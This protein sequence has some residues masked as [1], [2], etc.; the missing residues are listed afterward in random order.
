[1]IWNLNTVALLVPLLFLLTGLTITVMIDPYISRRNRIIM[2]VILALSVTLIA[3][4]LLE[5][6]LTAGPPQWFW[7]TTVA[8]YGY[9]VRPVFLILFL[10]I[11]QPEKKHLLA[12]GLAIVNWGIYMTAYFSHLCFWI[13]SGN[14][15]FRGP[16]AFTCLYVSVI[17]LGDLLVQSIRNNQT[18]G[19]Q[20]KLIPIF[21]VVMIL[22]SV[23][24]DGRVYNDR[25]PVTFLT[26][27]IVA[28]SVFYYIWLHLQFVR[29]HEDDLKAQQR[30][31]IMLGQ[32][33]P[34]FLYNSLGAIRST[35]VDDPYRARDAIDQ[36]SE[37]LRHNMDSLSD[38]E[39]ISFAT[40]LEHVKHF[41]AIQQLRFESA[42]EV[43]YDLECTDFRIP[44]LT[45][46][47]IVENAVTYGVRKNRKGQGKV[48]IRSREYPDRWEVSVIDNGPGFVPESLPGDGDRSHIGIQNV[49]DRLRYSVGGDLQ[50]HSV[51][52][53]GTT[54]T[55][56]LPKKKENTHA[57]IRHR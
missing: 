24:L 31:Q 51:L 37:Y 17:L 50:I 46:Q 47:P 10:Y 28:S 12:W 54:A 48:I 32:I 35:C 23:Y 53:E 49:R 45:L 18:G 13:S 55:I 39:P 30:M 56:I 26:I 7:R 42:L 57:D 41:L 15:F 3:Q 27:A 8:I 6:W 2:L 21:I 4:N 34:H 16:L 33:Q 19:K 40:E 43:E 14:G 5:D 38:D 52:G 44:T 25:Q 36:F 11:I 1:M 9:I 29:E 20:E 22:A